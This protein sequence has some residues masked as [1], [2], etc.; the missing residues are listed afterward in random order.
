[1]DVWW[2]KRYI[3]ATVSGLETS[4]VM[5]RMDLR[6]AI[7][8]ENRARAKEKPMGE[9]HHNILIF[10]FLASKIWYTEVFI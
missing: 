9:T 10:D 6:A 3:T 4:V 7:T 5:P 8:L 1:M 2:G